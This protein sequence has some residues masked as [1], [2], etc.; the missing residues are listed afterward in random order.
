[1]ERIVKIKEYIIAALPVCILFVII[2]FKL[3]VIEEWIGNLSP[4]LAKYTVSLF[5]YFITLC[6]YM[7]MFFEKIL[8]RIREKTINL[9]EV[10]LYTT[11][12]VIVRLLPLVLFNILFWILIIFNCNFN[13]VIMAGPTVYIL[14]SL[15]VSRVYLGEDYFIYLGNRYYYNKV[16]EVINN[17]EYGLSIKIEDKNYLVYCGSENIKNKL[18]EN[19][20]HRKVELNNK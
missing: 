12:Q 6:I 17:F 9:N 8:I 1:M 10:K 20:Y 19:I 13:I 11:F 16:S 14:R 18:K 7:L 3:N 2:L 4:L 5:L 15:L